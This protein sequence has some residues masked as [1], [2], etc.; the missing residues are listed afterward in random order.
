[1][2]NQ[3]NF[4][5]GFDRF[6]ALEWANQAYYIAKKEMGDSE[7]V[8]EIKD[9]LSK[10][11]EG[12]DSI[13][14]TSNLLS[15]LWIN[16]YPSVT[17]LREEAIMTELSSEKELVLFHWGLA[18]IIF[19]FFKEVM[20]QIGNL[21]F[22]QGSFYANDIETR[23]LNM[24]S[25]ISSIPRATTR[26]IQS[27]ESWHL[28]LKNSNRKYYANGKINVEDPK[29]LLWM[30]MAVLLSTSSKRIELSELLSLNYLFPFQLDPSIK[31]E[32]YLN[33]RLGIERDGMNKEII[34][35]K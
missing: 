32:I 15:R 1:M 19:P 29:R 24:Y 17:K 8:R 10:Y 11:I 4:L 13:R 27:L 3:N 22:V 2:R 23:M 16:A 26:V 28:L 33:Q 21:L 25:N 5:I 6:I 18:I 34:V 31:K 9:Y 7:K 35:L 14:K 30:L 20:S 12:K